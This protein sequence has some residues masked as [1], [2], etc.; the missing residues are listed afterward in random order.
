VRSSTP[1]GTGPF[2]VSAI[3]F[4]RFYD[5]DTSV[6]RRWPARLDDDTLCVDLTDAGLRVT[7]NRATHR[8]KPE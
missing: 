1:R 5:F 7:S 2:I 4:I 8:A 6:S 3:A